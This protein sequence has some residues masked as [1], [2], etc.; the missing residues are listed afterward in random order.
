MT[1]TATPH[2]HAT[3]GAFTRVGAFQRPIVQG[4]SGQDAELLTDLSRISAGADIPFGEV[5]RRLHPLPKMPE[6]YGAC[7]GLQLSLGA[8][9]LWIDAAES[10]FRA[11]LSDLFGGVPASSLHPDMALAA[12]EF[13]LA[14]WLDMVS[15]KTGLP[16]LLKG[17]H[18]E[19]VPSLPDDFVFA[20]RLSSGTGPSILGRLSGRLALRAIADAFKDRPGPYEAAWGDVPLEARLVAGRSV[21][22]PA[23]LLALECGDLVLFEQAAGLK[24]GALLFWCGHGLSFKASKN[25]NKITLENL[26]QPSE[27][28][29]IQDSPPVELD[30]LPVELLFDIG[31]KRFTFG[32]ARQLHAGS[33]V[34]LDTPFESGVTI[35]A[36]GRKVGSGEI[37]TV[38]GRTAVRILELFTPNKDPL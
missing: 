20:F 10:P 13:L 38:E 26:M 27:S 19:K 5:K 23:E 34:S 32:E 8:A 2:I 4:I 6:S 25:G 7:F 15:H 14:G 12:H 35:T 29:L 17:I 33:I 9:D 22:S 16:V 36:N 30:A 24:E 28:S 31:V 11:A 3:S 37:L 1:S 21:V 18:L